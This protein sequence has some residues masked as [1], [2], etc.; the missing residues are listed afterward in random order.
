[1]DPADFFAPIFWEYFH[2][3][4]TKEKDLQAE[5]RVCPKLSKNHLDLN[6]AAK[7]KVRLAVQVRFV[8]Y[9]LIHFVLIFPESV[10]CIL[11]ISIK[12]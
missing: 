10:I 11:L 3:L 4:Y 12:T 5:Y 7:M 8:V 1:M 2:M 6:S 9:N